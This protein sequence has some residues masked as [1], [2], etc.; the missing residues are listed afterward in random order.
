MN[1]IMLDLETMGNGNNAAIIAIGAVKFDAKGI[2]ERWYEVVSL[3]SSINVGLEVDSSTI[4]WWM[5]QSDDARAQFEKEGMELRNALI[6][7]S[8]FVG[9]D[10]IMWGNGAAFDNAILSNAYR[11]SRLDQP[12]SFRNDRCYR[13]IKNLYPNIEIDDIG[14]QHCAVDDA[15]YQAL[16]LIKIFYVLNIGEKL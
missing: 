15:E 13:T 10:P 11:K 9:N 5:K 4:M 16:H 12:W 2:N 6:D 1:N 8:Q 3:Q 7:F 14:I